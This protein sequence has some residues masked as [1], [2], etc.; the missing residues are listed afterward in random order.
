MLAV[1]KHVKQSFKEGIA[2]LLMRSRKPLSHRSVLIWRQ[3]VGH[4]A[5]VSAEDV[6]I[7]IMIDQEV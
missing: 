3:Y 2:K 6:G 4:K 7:V 5:I 1:A